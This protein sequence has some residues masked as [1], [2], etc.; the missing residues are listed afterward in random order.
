MRRGGLSQRNRRRISLPLWAAVCLS[1]LSGAFMAV[2]AK[3]NG[4]LGHRIDNGFAAA[5]ISFGS[6]LVILLVL[7]A[8]LPAG[9]RGVRTLRASLRTRRVAWWALLGGLGGALL[10]LSQALTGSIIGVSMFTI[11]VIGGQTIS[12]LILDRVGMAPGGRRELTI[13]RV[14]GAVITF[15]AVTVS[16]SLH[17]TSAVPLLLLALPFAAGLAIAWQQAVNGRVSV[18]AN[19]VL[20]STLVNFIAGSAGL[21]VALAISAAVVSI[22]TEYPAEWWLYTG[23]VLGIGFIFGLAAAV[24][25]TGV[26]LLGMGTVAGQLSAAIAL[27]VLLPTASGAP[28]V[29][30]F[31]A[32]L[33][34]FG[35]VLLAAPRPKSKPRAV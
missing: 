12:G 8:V 25:V 19:S 15:G 35:C 27:D 13:S 31:V 11:A 1:I 17:A 10:V 2:Q 30:T 34:V 6:G 5:A 4:E 21:F 29:I 3:V 7:V 28:D 14:V 26:L 22:P 20:T 32:T 23:G 18:A 16:L 24:Q 33:I 9:R